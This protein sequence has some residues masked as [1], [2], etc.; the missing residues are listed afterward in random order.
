MA[1]SIATVII[2]GLIFKW[3]FEKIKLPGI[4]GML[5]LGV[6][7]GPY[8]LDWISPEM[9]NIS[10]DLR[11]IALIIILLRAGLGISRST[12][13]KVGKESAKLAFIPDLIEGFAIAF[14][15]MKIFGLSF[16]E[17]GML[18]FIIAAVSPAVVV[19]SMLELIEK[20]KGEKKAI[21]TMILAGA[22]IDDVVAITMFS[23]FLG[24]YGGKNINIPVKIIEIPI[25]II[26]GVA[27]GAVVGFILV[28]IFKKFHIRDTR[29]VLYIIAISIFLTTLEDVL[30]SYIQIASLLGVMTI[31]F[32]LLEKKPDAA[33][34]I[35]KKFE[36]IWVFAEI[37]LFVLVGA[38][39]N[40]TVALNSGLKGLALITIGLLFRSLG[41]F[42]SLM[43]S[44][45]N[46][47]EKIFSIIGYIP[48]ATVQAAIGAVPLSM[49]VENGELILAVAVLSI[50]FTAPIG[51]FGIKYFG[52]KLLD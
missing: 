50:I 4:L 10:T 20:G 45:L 34:R 23:T 25:S 21:P 37:I 40:T 5:I 8:M 14:F 11:K 33:N 30:K 36:K 17:G 48:K 35:A 13:K 28:R 24:L 47:K 52:D 9:M 18:G 2:L 7:I 41:V 22:S 43:G 29:K 26:L 6:L 31:G 27:I 1:L 39:V 44:D 16:I 42:I 46:G 51:A 49:G 32:I 38:Q 3:L 15:S 12:L 19:P